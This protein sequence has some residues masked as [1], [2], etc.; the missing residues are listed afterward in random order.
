MY[1]SAEENKKS[2][3]DELRSLDEAAKQKIMIVATMA[4]MIVVVYVWFGYF[5]GLVRRRPTQPAIIAQ[6]GVAQNQTTPQAPAAPTG[7]FRR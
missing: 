1:M 7:D 6:T 2:F 4:I 3:I 5:N